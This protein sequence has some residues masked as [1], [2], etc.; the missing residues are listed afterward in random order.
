MPSTPPLPGMSSFDHPP[1]N[2]TNPTTPAIASFPQGNSYFANSPSTS[3]N[4]S[5]VRQRSAYP[6]IPESTHWTNTNSPV[7]GRRASDE[8]SQHSA[9]SQS[10]SI[11]PEPNE[12]NTTYS[13]SRQQASLPTDFPPSIHSSAPT[14]APF[15]PQMVS[16]PVSQFSQHHQYPMP[17]QAPYQPSTDR[18]ICPT[19]QK[20][21]S[22]PSSLKIHVYSHTGE[23][24][25]KC[26][27]EG[28]GK[29]FS[30]RSNMKRHEKG[31]HGG[32]S[33]S[34]EPNSPAQSVDQEL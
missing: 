1:G 8:L 19:C 20:A 6:P 25:F 15:D 3:V 28:C 33:T 17:A 5:N 24:P 31:C 10:R 29:F 27:Y 2:T 22:R 14:A 16:S 23:K 11:Y 12:S 7:S 18:Y 4:E 26:K 30:V 21:F 32:G 9:R 34:T 13:H